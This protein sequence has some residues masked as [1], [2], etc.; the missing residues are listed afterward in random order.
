VPFE[1]ARSRLRLAARKLRE[2]AE[3]A[4]GQP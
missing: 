2:R 4:G 1:T 3:Q